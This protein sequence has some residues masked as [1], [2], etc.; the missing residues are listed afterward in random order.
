MN[1][2]VLSVN[3]VS[4]GSADC[5]IGDIS[6]ELQMLREVA[7]AL[8]MLNAEKINFNSVFIIGFCF[9]AET[10]QQAS[11]TAKER[12]MRLNLALVILK[13]LT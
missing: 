9:H 6:R 13:Q 11:R 8:D 10:I 1:E 2:M 4:D 5:M 3:E 7:L 12:K